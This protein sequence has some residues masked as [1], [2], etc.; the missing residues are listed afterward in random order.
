MWQVDNRTPFAAERGW[1]R[2]RNGAEVWLVA[3]KCTFDIKPDGTTEV[4]PD[5]PPV[6]R[7]PE[8]TDE[9]GK[10]SLKYEADL[11]LTKT[12]T[13]VV[14]IGHAYA[15]EG[16]PVA[17]MEV[18]LRVGPIQK[19]VRVSG[20]RTWGG[21]GASPP[22][23]FAKMP[24][25]YERAF[26]GVD[27]RSEHPDRDWDW[28]NPVGTGFAV[29]RDNLAGV[30]LPNIEYPDEVVGAW[31]DRPRPAGF[32]PV[33]SHWQPRAGL[34]GTYDDDWMKKRRPLLPDDFDDRFFQYAPEDQQAPA[35][36]RGGEPVVL[37][38]LTPE[39][40]LRFFLPKVVLGFDTRFYDG[41]REIHK[42]R[43]LHAVILEPDY[44]RVSLV[45]HTAL[46]CHFKVQKLERTIVTLK[47]E[48]TAASA[49]GE[50]QEDAR[51]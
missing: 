12:T 18:G 19:V 8:Y 34:A 23:P 47:T 35:F 37:Y 9:P 24:L 22:R 28:R 1:V 45:W 50:P 3:V 13:D 49:E 20:D 48:V 39:G 16:R 29:S 21:H 36:L 32:G 40:D 44:P 6:L 41:T 46:P 31:S 51:A 7:V 4:S 33:G 17:Q 27:A 30:A 38:R 14:A 15:P 43:R 10:S 42:M 26:G 11:V 5:Q 25:T 2:D